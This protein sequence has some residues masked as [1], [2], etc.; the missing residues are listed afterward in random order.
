MSIMTQTA[1]GEKTKHA[2]TKT[3]TSQHGIGGRRA[4]D[5]FHRGGRFV[6]H[7]LHPI[8]V[9]FPIA[10]FSTA[11]IFGLL[12][13][14]LRKEFLRQAETWLLAF[15]LVSGVLAAIAGLWNEEGIIA[16]GVPPFERHETLGLSTLAVFGILLV[17]RLG[18]GRAWVP[19]SPTLYITLA[20][21]GLLGT[22][23]F[24]GGELVYRYGAGVQ[25]S[26]VSSPGT[27]SHPPG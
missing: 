21:A 2:K 12:G 11:V 13:V 20:A 9:H 23:G 16:A 6:S 15:G 7:P 22:T 5:V 27:G 4:S 1:T 18:K 10:L 17:L 24:F 3:N 19:R 14:L 26:A 8:L 25:P